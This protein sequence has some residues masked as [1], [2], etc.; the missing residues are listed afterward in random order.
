MK[1]ALT[2]LCMLAL[3]P[4]ATLASE[5]PAAEETLQA[6][7]LQKAGS[8]RAADDR[9]HARVSNLVFQTFAS[10]TGAVATSLASGSA[11]WAA[12]SLIHPSV[13]R[14]SACLRPEKQRAAAQR[15]SEPRSLWKTGP[16]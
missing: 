9:L 12:G 6:R 1:S 8:A 16:R 15:T 7:C 4:V 2:A 3:I 11:R 10:N 13:M 5:I 14:T